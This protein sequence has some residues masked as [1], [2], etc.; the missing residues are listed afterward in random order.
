MRNK[1]RVSQVIDPL[2]Q[3]SKQDYCRRVMT[4]FYNRIRNPKLLCDMDQTPVYMNSTPGRTV[5][6]KG[7]RF[8]SIKVGGTTGL[9]I[10]VAVTVAMDGSKLS[11]F[12]IFKGKPVKRL[13]KV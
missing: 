11:L 9:R 1:T 5:H 3:Q 10:T 12:I 7:A 4:T 2:L 8:V 13:A 6:R